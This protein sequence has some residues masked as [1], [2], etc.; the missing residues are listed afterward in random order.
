MA[1]SIESVRWRDL[2]RAS[3]LTQAM[4]MKNQS[5]N[6]LAWNSLSS[7]GVCA[8]IVRLPILSLPDGF[9]NGKRSFQ[10][11]DFKGTFLVNQQ[12]YKRTRKRRRRKKPSSPSTDIE[13]SSLWHPHPYW[14]V[15][16]PCP[17]GLFVALWWK[18]NLTWHLVWLNRMKRSV[19]ITCQLDSVARENS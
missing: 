12:W 2:L 19:S 5:R 7:V 9:L 8:L 6:C 1:Q 16:W 15:S 13:T 4:V 17:S 14:S 10:M 18:T 11:P 3:W